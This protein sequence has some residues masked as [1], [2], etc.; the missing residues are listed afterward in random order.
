MSS[1]FDP[2][3]PFDAFL[4]KMKEIHDSKRTDYASH[5]DPLGN[6]RECERIGL[7]PS[8]GI[9]VRMGDKWSR[10]N[11]LLR[12]LHANEGGPAVKDESLEDT[13]VDLANYSILLA[14]CLR[15][16]KLEKAQ[17]VDVSPVDMSAFKA[18]AT[19]PE[20]EQP[21]TDPNNDDLVD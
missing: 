12:R 16:E 6:F 10:I 3:Y 13:L 18:M 8:Q 11:N 21:S 4:L 14:V 20:Y 2:S 5:A 19:P 7:A 17:E 1:Y 9:M 15:Q